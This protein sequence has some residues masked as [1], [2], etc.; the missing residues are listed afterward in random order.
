MHVSCRPDPDVSG[1]GESVLTD[2][3]PYP[4]FLHDISGPGSDGQDVMRKGSIA[5]IDP[6]GAETGHSVS[7]LHAFG[8]NSSIVAEPRAKCRRLNEQ[9][10]PRG[11][12]ECLFA[13]PLAPT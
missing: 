1:K 2:G 12:A 3:S 13:Q 9:A 7:C 6:M 4:P 5:C 11:N 10:C 8:H